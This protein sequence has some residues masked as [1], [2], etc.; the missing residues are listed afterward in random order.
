MAGKVNFFSQAGL[1]ALFLI[2]F[3]R[4]HQLHKIM[5]DHHVGMHSSSSGLFWKYQQNKNFSS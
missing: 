3:S 1:T 5:G 4:W 2:V